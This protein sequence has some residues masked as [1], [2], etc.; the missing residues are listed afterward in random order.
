MRRCGQI[1]YNERDPLTMDA[2]AW[3]VTLLP[4]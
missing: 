3:A 2:E 4:R 1:N